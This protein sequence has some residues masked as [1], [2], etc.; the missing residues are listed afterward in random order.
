QTVDAIHYLVTNESITESL[1][2]KS[3]NW[4]QE[5]TLERF[6][7]EIVKLLKS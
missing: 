3:Q 2:Q 7:A 5:Y 6:E 1:S 4:A